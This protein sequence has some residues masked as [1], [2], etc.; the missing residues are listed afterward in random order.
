MRMK[1]SCLIA[2]VRMDELKV[3][4]KSDRESECCYTKHV[5]PPKRNVLS[6]DTDMQATCSYLPI[7]IPSGT[8]LDY[9]SIKASCS[10]LVT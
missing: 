7:A 3:M 1:M 6:I 10:L 4:L 5:L 2:V 8:H 9:F